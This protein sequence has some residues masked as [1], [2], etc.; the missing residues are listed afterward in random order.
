VAIA[1]ALVL[2]AG[3]GG[4]DGASDSSRASPLDEY[5]GEDAISFEGG[6]MSM[7][8]GGSDG[9]SYEPTEEELQEQRD[10]EDL[11][12][13]CMADQGFDYV[14]YV[15]MPGDFDGGPWEEAFSL[16]PD[17]FREKYGYG[18]STL[19][20][21]DEA[22][23]I[24]DPNAEIR[25]GL[26]PQ[27]QKEYD[28][29]LYGA[30]VGE[31]VQDSATEGSEPSEAPPTPEDLGCYG[32]AGEQIYD[33]EMDETN[34]PYMEFESLMD[35]VFQIGER[36]QGDSRIE[37]ATRAWKDC[38]ADSGYPEFEMP[39]DP[40]QQLWQ[41]WDELMGW[42]GP[43]EGDGEVAPDDDDST[44]SVDEFP[45][46]ADIDPAEREEFEKYELEV[47]H[48]DYACLKEHYTGVADEVQYEFE[49][50][51]VD[52]HR[53]ELER[54]REAMAEFDSGGALG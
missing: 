50:E 31:I 21:E 13:S 44:T 2:S 22:E 17:E 32:V 5:F 53:D 45:D 30:E 26:S 33:E 12:A 40:E 27:A 18:I 6:G 10:F 3:C 43:I 20:F 25:D 1:A 38:M 52:E 9:E 47:A 15:Y 41:R 37:A 42:S 29:A 48:A 4:G 19:N 51:F 39:G 54:Y 34:D 8:F 24:D 14:P 16:P 46:P 23:E 7:S 28:A 11:V 35:D 36:M 49:A